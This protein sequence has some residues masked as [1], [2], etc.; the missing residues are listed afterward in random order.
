MRAATPSRRRWFTLRAVG[1]AAGAL[2]CM[3]APM[4]STHV[5]APSARVEFRR[6]ADDGLL[7]LQVLNCRRMPMMRVN[8]AESASTAMRRALNHQSHR[9]NAQPLM[10][11]RAVSV[12]RALCHGAAAA[13][14]LSILMCH[15]GIG[16]MLACK[17]YL[18]LP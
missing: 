16:V 14:P 8:S 9:R 6:R 12:A 18:F 15:H 7:V 17:C 3:A 10:L 2:R 5:A 4:R 1:R 13:A 11:Q